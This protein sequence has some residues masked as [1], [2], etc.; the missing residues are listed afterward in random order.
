M[1]FAMNKLVLVSVCFA[2]IVAGFG[3]A[4]STP[5]TATTTIVGPPTPLLPTNDRL[6]ADDAA[7]NVP[8]D[9]PELSTVLNEDGLKRTETRAVKTPGSPSGA[10]W[11]R[12]YQFGDAT[13]AYAAYT[14]LRQG[15]RSTAGV[16]TN[17]TTVTLPGGEI[18]FLSG[19]SVVRAAVTQ[20]GEALGSLMSAIQTGLP[21][22]GGRRGLAPLLPTLLPTPGLQPASLRYA[23]GP[24]SYRQSGGVLPAEILGW[25]KSAETA[26]ADYA[27]TAGKGT[28]TLLL[29]P[30]PQIAGDRGRAIEQAVN[31]QTGPAAAASLGTV[32]LRRIGPLVGMTSGGFTAE[33][34]QQLLAG[35]HLNTELSYDKPMPLEFHAE[36]KK[37][38]TLLQEIAIFTGVAIL[39]ALVLGV[40]L[41]G[42]RAGIRV[43]QGKPAASEPEF[44]RIDLRGSPQPLG[45]SAGAPAERERNP[46][47]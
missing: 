13:G 32:K 27:G 2:G 11:V 40:F 6:V 43:L 35:L 41:G 23:L 1:G 5:P 38:V 47:R 3:V 28:L 7:A 26:T 8:A 21:K 10:G 45:S 25:D 22:I 14:Y 15:G 42:A 17:P 46:E 31:Q 36:I 19:V 18:L 34:A 9:K 20:H 39:A 44:L 12:A 24:V 4:Q 37:T 33:Q 29:Y 16:I 30:T